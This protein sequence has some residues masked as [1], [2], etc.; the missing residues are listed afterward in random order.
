MATKLVPLVAADGWDA[1][2][3]EVLIDPG[4]YDV[5]GKKW[6]RSIRPPKKTVPSLQEAYEEFMDILSVSQDKK[7]GFVTVAVDHYSPV[8]ARDWVSWLVNDLNTTIMRQDV[9]EA[10]Q[11]IE[12][13]NKQIEN[14]SLAALQGVFFSLIEEQTKTV[15]LA[16]VSK[17][18][19][20]KTIDPAFVPEEKLKL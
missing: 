6:I 20:F 1:E 7:S 16:S 18:Y 17:E 12:Y 13:L 15:M 11:A 3:G 14:T 19:V 2:S 5:S 10:E 4:D 9:A 8:V